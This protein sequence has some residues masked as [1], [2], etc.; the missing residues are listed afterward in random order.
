MLTLGPLVYRK[1]TFTYKKDKYYN[2]K[3]IPLVYTYR[4]KSIFTTN[5]L[6]KLKP[7]FI[8]L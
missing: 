7:I 5:I 2:L 8:S 3:A 4:A 6:K 1:A